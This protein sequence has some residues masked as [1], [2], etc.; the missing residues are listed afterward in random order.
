[1]LGASYDAA[2]QQCFLAE[3]RHADVRLSPVAPLLSAQGRS[4]PSG[5]AR[6]DAPEGRF[7]R[8]ASQAA[9]RKNSN[10]NIA[11]Q[12]IAEAGNSRGFSQW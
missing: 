11:V 7:I 2:L 8:V 9:Q 1:V 12:A 4:C 10:S 5:S 6:E 3:C